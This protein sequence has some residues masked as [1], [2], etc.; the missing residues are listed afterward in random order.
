MQNSTSTLVALFVAAV[1]IF[2]VPLVT[3]TTRNDNV[4][5]ENVK[6]IVE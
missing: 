4:V 3:L 6:L 5:Q 2:I 1:F